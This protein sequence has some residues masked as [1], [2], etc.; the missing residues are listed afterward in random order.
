MVLRVE[1][2]RVGLRWE[3]N[4]LAGPE[5]VAE[6]EEKIKLIREKLQVAQN[7]QKQYA[8]KRRK[9]LK[10]D[11]GDLVML[12]VSPWKGIIQFGKRGNLSPRFIGP[13]RVLRRVGEVAYCLDLPDELQGIHNVFHVSSLRKTLLKESH[14]VLIPDVHV[15]SSCNIKKGRWRFLIEKKRG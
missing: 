12:K 11:V 8:D 6:T 4:P 14:K 13:F 15:D 1:H 9:P 5:V 7:R 10:F 3:K 2:R